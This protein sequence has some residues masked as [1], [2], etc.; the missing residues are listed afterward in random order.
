MTQRRADTGIQQVAKFRRPVDDREVAA[1]A[2]M[3]GVN[4]SPLSMQYRH[5]NAQAGLVLG[6]AAVDEKDQM[7]GFRR[8]AA[9]VER[10]MQT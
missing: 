3:D 2:G 8:L 4:V 5:G 7:R 6:F 9:V 1:L 10:C